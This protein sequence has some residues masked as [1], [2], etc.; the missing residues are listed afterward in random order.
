MLHMLS[1]CYKSCMSCACLLGILYMHTRQ[2]VTVQA[3]VGQLVGKTLS[4]STSNPYAAGG[5]GAAGATPTAIDVFSVQAS[6]NTLMA[7]FVSIVFANWL[8]RLLNKG[9][10]PAKGTPSPAT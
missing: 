9:A 7:H 10:A 1:W 2:C 3:S 6:T 8:L 4:S 5:S